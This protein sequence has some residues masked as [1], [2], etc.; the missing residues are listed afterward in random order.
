[1]TT[2]L[3]ARGERGSAIKFYSRRLGTIYSQITHSGLLNRNRSKEET[4]MCHNAA[5]YS[6][7]ITASSRV[8]GRWYQFGHILHNS[9]NSAT[10]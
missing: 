8:I 3:A 7:E 9:P 2:P 5:S 10:T 6:V 4:S 1:M